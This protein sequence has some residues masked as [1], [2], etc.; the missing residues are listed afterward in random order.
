MDHQAIGA[1]IGHKNSE[2]HFR[3][4]EITATKIRRV[5]H[6]YGGVVEDRTRA[7]EAMIGFTQALQKS[8]KIAG[9]SPSSRGQ[10]WIILDLRIGNRL[11]REVQMFHA[12]LAQKWRGEL[13]NFLVLKRFK[14]MLQDQKATAGILKALARRVDYGHGRIVISLVA[15]QEVPDVWHFPRGRD[16]IHIM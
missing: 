8:R 9:R 16:A 13:A 11:W 14:Q 4:H 2:P 15:L 7:F 1:R 12:Q 6:L 10:G 5:Q 3:A